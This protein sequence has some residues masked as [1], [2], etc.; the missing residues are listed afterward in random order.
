EPIQEGLKK[1]VLG[2]GK[3]PV[4]IDPKSPNFP[5]YTGATVI[6]PN[7]SE[8][9]EASGVQIN[10]RATAAEA[11]RPLLSPWGSAT[12]PTPLGEQGMVLVS[13]SDT[14][15]PVIEVDTEA[16]EVFDVSGA[17]DTVSAVFLLALAVGAS[18]HQA[19]LLA[20]YAAGIVVAEVGTVSVRKEELLE[21]IN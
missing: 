14:K 8:A 4:L 21:R 9:S 16:Q 19:A 5:L 11:G 1:G 13:S 2:G 10:D 6:K 3:V 17:G 7:R 18:A 15:V 20:N 12:A